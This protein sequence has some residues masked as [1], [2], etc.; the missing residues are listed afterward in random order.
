MINKEQ[1]CIEHLKKGVLLKRQ[2]DLGSA[3]NEYGKAFN[4]YPYNRNI[5]NNLA[6]IFI[7]I[8]QQDYALRNLL[9]YAHLILFNDQINMDA[10]DY[11]STFYNWS[12]IINNKKIP[13]NLVL[14]AVSKDFN[15]AKIVSDINLTF[16]VGISYLLQNQELI[17]QNQIPGT[18]IN[19]EI[20]ILLGK[21]T[22]GISLS[23][24]EFS[25]L[26]R[27]IGLSFLLTNLITN[28]NITE[29]DII[30]MYLDESYKLDSI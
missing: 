15:L 10:Y 29:E 26:V 2:G 13:N 7:G 4:I 9:T 22:E 25:H 11:A 3:I 18:L 27:T 8:N 23:N 17:R 24:S 21:P 1:L 16:N 20:N 14:S 30:R 6:K 12:G 19:N 28:N 5:Y